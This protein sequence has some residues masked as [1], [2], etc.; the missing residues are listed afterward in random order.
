MLAQQCP[1]NLIR[2]DLAEDRDTRPSRK[3]WLLGVAMVSGLARS[4]PQAK[5]SCRRRLGISRCARPEERRTAPGESQLLDPL[6]VEGVRQAM[7]DPEVLE[8]P[9]RP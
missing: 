6:A 1:S 7:R 9:Q 5:R 8:R 2:S 4:G 3:E